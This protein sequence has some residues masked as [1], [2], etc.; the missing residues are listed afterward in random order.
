MKEA[1]IEKA[2]IAMAKAAGYETRKVKFIA[3]NGAPDRI[4]FKP[5]RFIWVEMKQ[6]SGVVS[7][8][9]EHQMNLLSAAGQEVHVVS[10]VDQFRD[11]IS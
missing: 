3:Q 1:H 5:G 2:C 10:T 4:F 7:P 8:L 9:Q 11:L 6:K